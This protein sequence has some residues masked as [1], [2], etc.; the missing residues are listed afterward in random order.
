LIVIC[1]ESPTIRQE[2]CMGD[3]FPE[4]LFVQET[5]DL[6]NIHYAY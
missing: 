4:K 2:S 1:I 6:D 3:Y 5:R